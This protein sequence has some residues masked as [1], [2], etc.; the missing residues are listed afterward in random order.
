M[1]APPRSELAAAAAAALLRLGEERPPA[2]AMSLLQRKGRNEWRPREEEPRK[3]SGTR[4]DTAGTWGH[5]GGHTGTPQGC[6]GGKAAPLG[7]PSW[8]HWEPQDHP[9]GTMGTPGTALMGTMGAPGPPLGDDGNPWDHPHGTPG[10]PGPPWHHSRDTGSPR[11]TPGRTLMAVEHSE[12]TLGSLS[13]PWDHPEGSLGAPGPLLGDPGIPQDPPGRSLSPSE[14]PKNPQMNREPLPKLEWN[15]PKNGNGVTQKGEWDPPKRGLGPQSP[16]AHAHAVSGGF[17][18]TPSRSGVPLTPP[19]RV[20]PPRQGSQ[21]AGGGGPC[22]AP[23][24][25]GS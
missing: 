25:W 1:S 9:W 17:R 14:F 11:T 4:G 6:L 15:P 3:G 12:G 7:P 13:P 5:P 8:G 2:A 20:P 24:A 18:G 21:G 22:G 16:P 23:C 10:V 19:P